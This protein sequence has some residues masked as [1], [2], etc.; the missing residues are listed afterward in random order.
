MLTRHTLIL[1]IFLDINNNT[2]VVLPLKYVALVAKW[3]KKHAH[4]YILP[5]RHIV[6]VVEWSKA[7]LWFRFL[8]TA[9]V[10]ILLRQILVWEGLSLCLPKVTIFLWVLR[11][12]TPSMNWLPQY[13]RKIY[14]SEKLHSAYFDFLKSCPYRYCGHFGVGW[15]RCCWMKR[16]LDLMVFYILWCWIK[17][18]W[19]L[20]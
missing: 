12:S 5:L 18:F 2:N 15:V 16:S 20:K 11:F 8:L 13:K 10:W 1:Y 6:L 4:C 14:W 17:S 3:Y 7:Y 9:K 19:T